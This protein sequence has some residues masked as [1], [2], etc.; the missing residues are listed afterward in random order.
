MFSKSLLQEKINQDF[1]NKN[2]I[3]TGYSSGIGSQIYKHLLNLGANL[4]SA[5]KSLIKASCLDL[6]AEMKE[7][8]DKL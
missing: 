7:C 2:F 3:L 8:L 5:K 4:K 6:K 1:K